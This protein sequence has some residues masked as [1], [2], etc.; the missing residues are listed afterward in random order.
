MANKFNVLLIASHHGVFLTMES[1]KRF[2]LDIG[3]LVLVIPEEKIEKYSAMEG[4]EFKNYQKLLVKKAK[5]LKKDA[6]IFTASFDVNRRVSQT[7]EFLKEIEQTGIWMQVAA[8]S[9]VNRLPSQRIYEVMEKHM[10]LMSTTRCYE[11][12]KRLD[13][14]MML[15]QPDLRVHE[16]Q[17]GQSFL[18]NADFIKAPILPDPYMIRDAM[19]RQLFSQINPHAFSCTEE[20]VDMAFSGKQLI[21]HAAAAQNNMVADYWVVAMQPKLKIDE[22]YAYPL[23]QYL[24]FVDKCK[25]LIPAVTLDRIKANAT[26]AKNYSLAFREALS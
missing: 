26:E 18:I 8:G 25:G 19:D 3:E 24:P 6:K 9:V 23:E 14:Y 21:D 10:L 15:G 1:L 13:M 11:G 16:K 7:A 17:N 12:D 22:L 20:L 4:D 2:K 5:Q